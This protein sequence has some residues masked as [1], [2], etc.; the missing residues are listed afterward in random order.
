MNAGGLQ[1]S[2]HAQLCSREVQGGR[3][4]YSAC[5][6]EETREGREYTTASL[7]GPSG[8]CEPLVKTTRPQRIWNE[9]SSLVSRLESPSEEPDGVVNPIQMCP[10]SSSCPVSWVQFSGYSL[11]A[12]PTVSRRHKPPSVR[13]QVFL[14][15]STPRCPGQRPGEKAMPG[16]LPI[17]AAGEDSGQVQRHFQA[18]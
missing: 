4:V 17:P 2:F 1:R 7:S 6:A 14:P 16:C 3:R 9:G 8:V 15:R 5:A 13:R 12:A 10:L 18:D 11:R